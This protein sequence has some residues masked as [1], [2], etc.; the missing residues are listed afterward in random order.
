MYE[1]G[2]PFF[3]EWNVVISFECIVCNFH[4]SVR[5]FMELAKGSFEHSKRKTY[6]NSVLYKTWNRALVYNSRVCNI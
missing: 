6:K 3:K 5:V 4:T 1:N 2:K